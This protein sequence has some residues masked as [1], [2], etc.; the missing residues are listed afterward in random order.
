MDFVLP[1]IGP[2]LLIGAIVVSGLFLLRAWNNRSASSYAPYNV[3]RQEAQV[4]MRVNVL[5]ALVVV[6]VGAVLLA[7]LFISGVFQPNLAEELEIIFEATATQPTAT[8]TSET[9]V[10]TA[11][12]K[13]EATAS[14][15][16]TPTPIFIEDTPIATTI[17]LPT[18]TNEPLTAV[19]SSGV[20][21][22]LRSSPSLEGDQLEWLLE[23]TEL[24]FLDETVEGN[25]F[26]WQQVQTPAGTVG[27]V[28]A[29]F[30]QL[31]ES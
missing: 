31:L 15:P 7:V 14:V 26:N 13:A 18:A 28:A 8:V 25:T 30:V 11:T 10:N 17:P 29:D 4:A 6:V 24:I 2:L 22:W 16:D 20:G 1:L 27:W 3:G 19:V 12:P 5:R 9:I 21:V 23:G